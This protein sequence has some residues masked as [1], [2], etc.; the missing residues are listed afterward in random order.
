MK[1]LGMACAL[2]AMACAVA[3]AQG[4]GPTDLFAGIDAQVL[5]EADMAAVTGGRPAYDAID[6]D[7]MPPKTTRPIAGAKA[8]DGTGSRDPIVTSGGT[9]QKQHDGTDYPARAGTPVRSTKDGKVVT[10]DYSKGLGG[11]I[12]VSNNDGTESRYYHVEPR[13][14]EGERV[15]SGQVVAAVGVSGRERSGGTMSTGDHLH[16]EERDAGGRV[17]TTRVVEHY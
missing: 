12:T 2:F 15:R 4:T 11:K 16:Y 3:M 13:V 7:I 10:V 17:I 9:T 8:G 1:K 14:R 6:G 5:S